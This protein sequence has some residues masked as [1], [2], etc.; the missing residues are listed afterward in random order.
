MISWVELRNIALV[1]TDK[2]R[3]P[4]T[5]GGG[6]GPSSPAVP[7]LP[8]DLGPETA[9]L[10]LAALLGVRRRAGGPVVAPADRPDATGTGPALHQ[11]TPGGPPETIAPRS[12]AKLLELVLT[13]NVVRPDHRPR[14]I[15][16][17][18]DRCRAT[19]HVLP[20]QLLPAALD[21]GRRSGD[22]RP[23][24][25][26]V[27]GQRGH[28]LASCNPAWAW[29]HDEEMA[30]D[31]PLDADTLLGLAGEQRGRALR[32][33]RHTDPAAARTLLAEVLPRSSA[34]DRAAGLEALEVGLGP[35][36][37]PLL[38]S[39]LDDRSKTVR[40]VARRLLDGLP[41]SRRAARLLAA[42]EPLV[43]TGGLFHRGVTVAFPQPDTELDRRDL[44]DDLDRSTTAESRQLISLVA[45]APLAWWEQAL[46]ATPAAI[47]GR[48]LKPR[49]EL[50]AG[51][52]MAA[53]AERSS[54]WAEA[55]LSAGQ[56]DRRL[57][58]VADEAT[59]AAV[60]RRAPRATRRGDVGLPTLIATRSGPWGEELSRALLEW[61]TSPELS[62]AGFS[63]EHA[64]AANLHPSLAPA[65]EQFLSRGDGNQR[66]Q[67]RRVVHVL[68]LH[69]SITEAFP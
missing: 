21:H 66:L 57:V 34:A 2:R 51:W 23:L 9:A 68:S 5:A 60:I 52:V 67:L 28:W 18:L 15:R 7:A 30:A 13:G 26:A 55:L 54:P 64:F 38:E 40:A 11:P 39:A 27:L 45:G 46:G 25:A 10:H 44:H 8:D 47:V 69:T 24:L 37:E 1:G 3:L 6:P 63:F 43:D 36:D 59:L 29:A 50:L 35:D 62:K 53:A 56:L 49:R 16:H 20:H 65:I 19:G 32:L 61:T 42:L 48:Q 22:L 14:L 17:W 33:R 58:E 12:A 41:H 31:R 4:A